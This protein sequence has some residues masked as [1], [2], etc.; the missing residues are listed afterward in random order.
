MPLYNNR[1]FL[2]QPRYVNLSKKEI[3]EL[4]NVPFFFNKLTGEIFDNY[5]DYSYK[6]NLYSANIWECELTGKDNLKYEEALLN[7]KYVE[8]LV[9]R[10]LGLELRQ[11]ILKLIDNKTYLDSKEKSQLQEKVAIQLAKTFFKNELVL[12]RPKDKTFF[13]PGYIIEKTGEKEKNEEIINYKIRIMGGNENS[14]VEVGSNRIIHHGELGN[15]KKMRLKLL[16]LKWLKKTKESNSHKLLKKYEK[17]G[18]PTQNNIVIEIP[19]TAKEERNILNQN[20]KREIENGEGIQNLINKYNVEEKINEA[21]NY[22]LT[23][24]IILNDNGDRKIKNRAINKIIEGYNTQVENCKKEKEKNE[25]KSQLLNNMNAINNKTKIDDIKV[26]IDLTTNEEVKEKL[27][28]VRYP[29]ED[30]DIDHKLIN[31]PR[32][33]ITSFKISNDIDFADIFLIWSF[34]STFNNLLDI[35]IIPL[36]DIEQRLSE[37]TK[38]DIV[39][40][41]NGRGISRYFNSTTN[42]F[43]YERLISKLLE[44]MLIESDELIELWIPEGINDVTDPNNKLSLKDIGDWRN[45]RA[46]I[47][48]NEWA[49][50]LTGAIFELY[51]KET[52]PF[53]K[54][55]INEIVAIK[56]KHLKE[57]EAKEKHD[58]KNK[59]SKKDKN[60][61]T[62]SL[63]SLTSIEADGI[64]DEVLIQSRKKIM[65]PKIKEYVFGLGLKH[66]VQLIKFL[67][68]SAIGT[69]KFR[70]YHEGC[71]DEISSDRKEK[72]E[73]QKVMKQHEEE[74]KAL[75]VIIKNKEKNYSNLYD[76]DNDSS[77]KDDDSKKSF[78]NKRKEAQKI[79]LDI[80]KEENKLSKLKSAFIKEEKRIE[81]LNNNM[82]KKKSK[83]RYLPIGEDRFFNKY[84]L[85]SNHLFGKTEENEK[86]KIVVERTFNNKT[87]NSITGKHLNKYR[88]K[89]E[90]GVN[91]GFYS[92]E[93]ELNEL[94]DWCTIKGLREKN[95]KDALLS[96]KNQYYE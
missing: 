77:S 15:I 4:K 32:P 31:H 8:E 92:T 69:T 68:E 20:G 35:P 75:E 24:Q 14:I 63:S 58:I 30:L 73:L 22:V 7:E 95:L 37:V 96:V 2:R 21:Y 90:G 16:V 47:A 11:E 49:C 5:R 71:I 88:E 78:P 61:D 26:V 56:K 33:L 17:F 60:E 59:K 81:T 65:E 72:I 44:C 93:S 39:Q 50:V 12:F 53:G 79:K 28:Y 48:S 34:I 9:I 66:K 41:R 62:S 45:A 67:I 57:I 18:I 10:R 23:H 52:L 70:E 6:W 55:Y 83:L 64:G 43:P 84:Y 76:S 25:L 80:Q 29:I 40:P 74:I 27:V 13:I 94:I 36:I 89:I 51:C 46:P 38:D 82:R 91:W 54:E 85:I 42:K 1:Q 19:Y 87:L 3:Q 86:V